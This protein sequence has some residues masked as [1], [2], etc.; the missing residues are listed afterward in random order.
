MA[1]WIPPI[2]LLQGIQG[3][4]GVGPILTLPPISGYIHANSLSRFGTSAIRKFPKA[5]GGSQTEC[6][7]VSELFALLSNQLRKKPKN[8]INC[9]S[10]NNILKQ[11]RCKTTCHFP[12]KVAETL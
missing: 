4:S 9:I 7:Q 11:Q 8:F 6:L 3:A 2:H 12:A 5:G 1:S 10:V